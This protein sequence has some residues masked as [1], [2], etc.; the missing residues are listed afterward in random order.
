MVDE[1]TSSLTD[2]NNAPK[3]RDA[4]RSAFGFDDAM[5]SRWMEIAREATTE[6]TSLGRLGRYE[7]LA[8]AGRGGQGIVYKAKQPGTNRTIAIK[9]LAAGVHASDASRARFHREVSLVASLDHPGIVSVLGMEEVP[10]E[11]GTHELLLMEWVDGVAIDH[12]A[13][14]QSRWQDVLPVFVQVC[15]AVA[16][17]HQRGVMHRDL[18]PSNI[19]V[20]G[21]GRAR[22]LDFG[23]ARPTGPNL[24]ISRTT[25]FVGT[26][27]YASPEAVGISTSSLSGSSLRNGTGALQGIDTRSDIFS[28][29][30]VLYRL[31]TK[32]EPFDS[33]KG[34][35]P[36][37]DA[38]RATEPKSPRV[39]VRDV[40]RELEAIVLKALRKSPSD[41]YQS[42]D[43]FAT[44]LRRFLAGET[45]VAVPPSLGYQLR[46]LVRRHRAASVVAVA[47]LVG[48]LLFA[49]TATWLAIKLGKERD[50]LAAAQ[51]EIKN[52]SS[53]V[54]AALKDALT[55]G[56]QH[57]S[58]SAFLE[59][60]L[61]EIDNLQE[62]DRAVTLRELL[63]RAVQ[64]LRAGELANQP[65]EQAKL[66]LTLA[67]AMR[68]I[69]QNASGLQLAQEAM[70]QTIAVFGAHS[71]EAMRAH[72]VLGLHYESLNDPVNSLAHYVSYEQ[73]AHE[74]FGPMHEDSIKATHNT[75]VALRAIG[76]YEEALERHCDA[77]SRRAELFGESSDA[78]IASERGVAMSYRGMRD[79]KTSMAVARDALARATIANSPLRIRMAH[80]VAAWL[81]AKTQFEEYRSLQEWT[82]RECRS[83]TPINT[84]ELIRCLQNV[85]QVNI[86]QDKPALALPYLEESVSLA[87]E[88]FGKDHSFVARTKMIYAQALCAAGRQREGLQALQNLRDATSASSDN[89][90]NRNY[91]EL[92]DAIATE[93]R[94][95]GELE[96]ALSYRE[97]YAEAYT[98]LTGQ[99]DRSVTRWEAMAQEARDASRLDKHEYALARALECEQASRAR[100]PK[101]VDLCLSLAKIRTET[102]DAAGSADALAQAATFA[103]E[104]AKLKQR[105]AD[106]LVK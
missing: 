77:W 99:L 60:I 53:E 21:T 79:T 72:H 66:F 83:S 97:E 33:S 85:A 67:E 43:A 47:G 103:G 59:S 20:D 74:F 88:T 68:G 9:R 105:I 54:E 82:L 3:S 78:A 27:A 98:H 10:G 90:N 56:E 24:T 52:K 89:P 94:K 65:G 7:L 16:F 35:G 37:F 81:D 58:T 23:L 62:R 106:S 31:L 50:A 91:L 73:L 101:L 51:V 13:D 80:L 64:R 95:A 71:Q 76:K 96:L 8:E 38:I 84:S 61:S 41:R 69:G 40:P 102:G 15:D 5:D 46:S 32:R 45:V 12:W 49:G 22:V 100:P 14:A 19:L 42:V 92:T 93:L 2:A 34:I 17:A 30:A 104:D 57:Q 70:S 4:F 28:L 25:G 29:G 11:L 44:D 86:T 36:L 55:K 18:K 75:G 26:P 48:V 1:P 39:I 87:E 6:T 63:E